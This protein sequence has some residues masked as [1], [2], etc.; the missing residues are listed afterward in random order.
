MKKLFLLSALLIFACS[1][2][3]SSDNDNSDDNN[4]LLNCD[5]SPVPT[6]VYGTQEWTVENAC[7]TAYKDGTP[8]P[9][10]TDETEWASLTTGAW[11]YYY[12]SS[13]RILYNGYAVMGVHDNDPNTPNK[14]FAPTG[15]H[16]PTNQEWL[17]FENYLISNG[18]NHDGTVTGNKIAKALASNSLWLDLFVIEGDV[19]YE[20]VNNNSSGFNA[21]PVGIWDT[22]IFSEFDVSGFGNGYQLIEEGYTINEGGLQTS[23]WSSSVGGDYDTYAKML[24]YYNE[25]LVT[26]SI[27]NEN[28]CSVRLVKD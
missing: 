2:D 6:I 22:W 18:Y 7:H 26:Y 27:Y 25:N 10:V 19:G 16:V 28:G 3:D 17:T 20:Q 4:E 21:I 8:I 13:N 12:G 5:G 1:S 24:Y 23:F 15:W 14:E 11:C 9:Q